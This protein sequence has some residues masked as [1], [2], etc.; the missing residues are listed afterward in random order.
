[1]NNNE[2]GHRRDQIGSSGDEMTSYQSPDLRQRLNSA[3]VAKKAML[4]KH[5]AA[6]QDP[7]LAKRHA[8]RTAMNEARLV[9][10]AERKAANKAREAERNEQAARAA[11]FAS[12]AAQEA[13]KIEAVRVAEQAERD[14][15]IEVEK[16][17]A[18]DARY[19][20]RKAAKRR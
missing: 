1:M 19:A 2:P 4:E 3:A 14:A 15:L 7:E 17:A 5:R 13:E 6:A 10:V 11:E 16:K 12:Q 9:R 20:A 18:R 8:A